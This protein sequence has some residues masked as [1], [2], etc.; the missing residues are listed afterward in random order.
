M[1]VLALDAAAGER[2]GT[3]VP[4]RRIRL[5]SQPIAHSTDP[6]RW[7]WRQPTT[8]HAEYQGQD[9]TPAVAMN[10][11][12]KVVVVWRRKQKNKALAQLWACEFTPQTGWSLGV[13]IGAGTLNDIE[14][15]RIVMD[16]KGDVT[17]VWRC[18]TERQRGIW[19]CHRIGESGWRTPR[20]IH[21]ED[22]GEVFDPRVAMNSRG[23]TVVVWQGSNGLRNDIWACYRQPDG[24]WSSPI[25]VSDAG[26][27][28]AAAP[29]VAMDDR[30][31]AVVVWRQFD[32]LCTSIWTNRFQV[33]EGWG[34][35]SMIGTDR[36]ATAFDPQVV[37]NPAGDAI[38]LWTQAA[39]RG[40]SVIL[41]SHYRPSLGWRPPLSVSAP[42]DQ[43]ALLPQISIDESG[44][45]VAV[46]DECGG[47]R[48]RVMAS[49]YLLGA[50]WA[51]PIPID[52]GTLSDMGNAFGGRVAM[53]DEGGAVAV[54]QRQIGS[55]CTV[56]SSVLRMGEGWSLARDLAT[57][58]H[59]TAFDPQLA[60]DPRGGA[61]ALWQT[62]S[63]N[64]CRLHAAELR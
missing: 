8:L 43:M 58:V 57:D 60:I 27:S 49:H 3:P 35:V 48:S 44:N 38:V 29:Q 25:Q 30:G 13:L 41:A 31:N 51:R 61:V 15:P 47:R 46:W 12:G 6:D 36:S 21:R 37:M 9:L 62:R 53:N 33:G 50:G 18:S 16:G 17:A 4:A 40:Q 34:R 5:R 28:D 22:K 20:R 1:K 55:Q 32:G 54:W 11:D 24:D 56:R 26:V 42:G 63:D 23:D 10:G 39:G 19:A 45:A 7:R 59:G 64:G 52:A 2:S 14:Y